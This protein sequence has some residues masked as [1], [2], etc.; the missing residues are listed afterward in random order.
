MFRIFL[1]ILL[2]ALPLPSLAQ[3][4]PKT[5][6]VL[7]GSGS[8]WGQIDGVNKIVIAREVMGD[9]LSTL[10]PEQE[11][12]LMSYGHRRK[13]DCN[14]IELLIE[15]GTDR[16]AIA[17]AVN[18]ISP[19]GKTPL[20]DAVIQAAQALRYTEEIANVIL[21]SD[22]I[23]TCNMDPCAVGRQLEEAGINFTAHV[24]GFDVADPAALA[25]LQCL[26][27][28]TGGQF[29][30]ADNA[31]ELADA[32]DEVVA[33]QPPVI[34]DAEVTF[35]AIEGAGG[36]QITEGLVW[37]IS[38]EEAGEII[39]NDTAATE[40]LNVFPGTGTASVMRTS[41]E[42]S[43]EVNF[44]VVDDTPMTVTLVLPEPAPP[45]LPEATIS[46][47]ASAPAGSTIEVSWTGPNAKND[48]VSVVTPGSND[49]AMTAKTFTSEGS[50]LQIHL[51]MQTGEYEIRYVMNDGSNVLATQPITLTEIT[52]TLDAPASIAIGEEISV[53]W[54]GP[55]YDRDF[56]AIAR[57]GD[58]DTRFETR[59]YTG[60]GNPARFKVPSQPGDYELR[61]AA[62]DNGTRVL[63]R[64]PL[65]VEAVSATLTAP[66]TAV[67]GSTIQ[68]SWEG[69]NASNDYI[70]VAKDRS[71]DNYK[72][73][74]IHATA[75]S[76]GD[77]VMPLVAGTY[78]L[79]YLMSNG[80]DVLA[81]KPITITPVDV[82]LN[83]PDSVAAGS[84]IPIDWTG[85]SYDRDY[86]SVAK[87]GSDD[88][89]Y[90]RYVFT[91]D[92]NPAQLQAPA[93]PG[94]YELRY[95]GKAS[96]DVMLAQRMITV[97]PGEA[98]LDAVASAQVGS[99]IT[100]AWTGPNVDRDYIAIAK[101]G[102]PAKS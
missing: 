9:L 16:A 30:T 53:G 71:A 42:A 77:L 56:I 73:N 97:T 101:P 34:I 61:Y 49:G 35:R 27:S 4:A 3:D 83:A 5:I 55:N 29:L 78:E 70:A 80:R 89:A 50:P 43:A 84:L 1:S 48:Y 6:L 17:D 99:T 82:T 98:T 20:S 76:Q 52:A 15:P 87:P 100:V 67:A 57:P 92:G 63:A 72:V 69:P 38:T 58:R 37:N 96:N 11:L 93:K 18:A 62:N 31:D 91:A 28:E 10:P 23:E 8:M 94:T 47:P 12:G 88:D 25:Q 75:N 54:E 7:D 33:A 68:I 46:G 79:R 102:D 32:L 14:D 44:T 59:A 81:R 60:N 24:I 41:D 66:D 95:V 22:G 26:A 51:P 90:I 2:L 19:K 85:P 39:V 65:A 13:G 21:V 86:L 45:A 64:Q 40:L 74:S 36:P